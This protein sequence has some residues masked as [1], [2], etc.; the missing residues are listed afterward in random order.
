MCERFWTPPLHPLIPTDL[1]RLAHAHWTFDDDQASQ[2]KT[3]FQR[4]SCHN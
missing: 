4:R 2:I 3:T 1:R